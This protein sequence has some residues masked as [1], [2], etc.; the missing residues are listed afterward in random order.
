[1]RPWIAL[2]LLALWHLPAQAQAPLQAHTLADHS[3]QPPADTDPRW[4]PQPL[5]GI[6]QA[7]V[8]WLRVTFDLP[9]DPA[10]PAQ[11]LAQALYLPYLYGGGRFWL[12]HTPFTTTPET[13]PA[14]QVRW[15]RPHLLAL[16]QA[17]LR[18]GRNLLHIRAT[19]AAQS[20]EVQWP[21]LA[22][23][24]LA[25]LQQAHDQRLLLVRTLPQV[26]LASGTVVG[27]LVLSIWLRRRQEVAYGLFGLAAVLWALRTTT[28]T[29]DAL[30]SAW[31]PAWRLLYYTTTGGFIVALALFAMHLAG[32]WRP[33]LAWALLGYVL[34]GPL[35]FGLAGARADEW[36]GRWWVLGLVPLALAVPAY[37]LLAAWRERNAG[38]L[39]IA[40]AVLLA[41]PAGV[42][43]Y[44]VAWSAPWMQ[45]ALPGWAGQRLFLLHHA[46][47]L[48]L[49]V[50]G[51]VLSTRLVR[52]LGDLEHANRT[53]EA[54]VAA[55]ERDIAANYEQITEL[56]RQQAVQG[57]RQRM[58][59]DLHDG[60][61]SQLFSSLVRAERGAL[62]SAEAAQTLRGAIDEMRVAIEALSPEDSDFRSAFGSFRH[63]W[64]QRLR[65]AG[66]ATQWAVALPDQVLP[67][68]PEQA[69][70]LLRVAQE[71]LT[72]VLKHARAS[73]VRVSLHLDPQGLALEV[74]D[75]GQPAAPV[76]APAP[77]P[78]PPA[79]GRGLGNMRTRA[80][81]L[82]GQLDTQFG[83][84]GGRVALRLP[85]APA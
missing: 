11:A 31:W 64:D 71:A 78:A 52:S 23:G 4:Q 59:Q 55:R 47:N 77:G 1:V 60:L 17:T 27:L 61:G 7:P 20:A 30:P 14:L 34:L 76:P 72:N 24:P 10:A 82:G 54:R 57:E 21:P 68:T 42:H 80:A 22:V 39:L 32:R 69:L 67:L 26:T 66:L 53:L 75:N 63:R 45:Q 25:P 15:E 79:G 73:T 50:M 48:L 70:Q 51:V 29:L 81:R 44:L 49:V 36:V 8:L 84:G 56:R 41:V 58:V 3:D 74:R 18:P 37:A 85:L 83:P 12:N 46:A 13:T 2:L 43:D 62:D 5:P 16:P 35:L 38:N 40:L 19:P 9:A 65:D 6:R 28:F 33:R